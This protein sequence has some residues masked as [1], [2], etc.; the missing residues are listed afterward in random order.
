M[1][2]M[3]EVEPSH[4]LVRKAPVVASSVYATRLGAYGTSHR[5]VHLTHMLLSFVE[6]RHPLRG[7]RTLRTTLL[8]SAAVLAAAHGIAHDVLSMLG[9][10][11]GT[12]STECVN[13]SVKIVNHRV[14]SRCCPLA[15]RAALR[16]HD[17]AHETLCIGSRSL[18]RS[19]VRLG[20]CSYRN[21][22]SLQCLLRNVAVRAFRRTWC[23]WL[24]HR[25]RRKAFTKCSA[26]PGELEGVI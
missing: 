18:L 2:T 7:T 20:F 3:F 4:C 23:R 9:C 17:A 24:G 13:S 11:V 21:R 26:R 12:C 8:R 6:R 22:H 16:H 10:G 25:P 14:R 15:I 1:I 5:N 19:L